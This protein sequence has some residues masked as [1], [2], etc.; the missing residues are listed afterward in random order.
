MFVKGD[1]V[2]FSH[3]SERIGGLKENSGVIMRV[4]PDK[5]YMIK[6]VLGYYTVSES[7]ITRRINVMHKL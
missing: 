4:L 7:A 6:N 3:W 5:K 2:T 1:E